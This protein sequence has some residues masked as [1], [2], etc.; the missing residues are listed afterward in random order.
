MEI[1]TD[2]SICIVKSDDSLLSPDIPDPDTSL[3]EPDG[4]SCPLGL[5]LNL[6][7]NTDYNRNITEPN[8]TETR[9]RLRSA[10]LT[11]VPILDNSSESNAINIS[12]LTDSSFN[13]SESSIMHPLSENQVEDLGLPTR[14]GDVVL[15]EKSQS[16]PPSVRSS[17]IPSMKDFVI[18]NEPFSKALN[19]K[20]SIR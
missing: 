15:E 13:S 12:Q 7:I 14:P 1:G 17:D 4:P 9:R 2:F 6:S 20:T 5:S 16:E 3:S 11:E 18:L 10:V 8:N 19:F